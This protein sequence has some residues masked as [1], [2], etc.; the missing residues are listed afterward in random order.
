M[1]IAQ[2]TITTATAT[3]FTSSGTNAITAIYLMNDHSGTVTVQLHIVSDG[4]SIGNTNKIIK[5]L[6]IAAGDTF[7]VDTERLILSN[8]DRIQ[9]TADVDSVCYSTISYIGV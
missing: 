8:N 5:N 4:D 7:V 1:S 3:L 9:A 2:G 6:E